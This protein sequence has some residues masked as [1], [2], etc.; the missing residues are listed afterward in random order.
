[1]LPV[2]WLRRQECCL[3]RSTETVLR[4]PVGFPPTGRS[5]EALTIS[6][7]SVLWCTVALYSTIAFQL[8]PFFIGYNHFIHISIAHPGDCMKL[9]MEW[10]YA[11]LRINNYLNIDVDLRY[12]GFLYSD[13]L[14]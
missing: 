3:D 11:D 14:Y 13:Y 10:L 2:E 12:P 9:A 5:K 6:L 4:S 8:S 1:M 7:H